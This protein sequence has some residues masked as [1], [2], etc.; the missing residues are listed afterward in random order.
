MGVI[1]IVHPLDDDVRPWLDE[2]G[3]PYPE[4]S[5]PS[6]H[7][8]PAEVRTSMEA[9]DGYTVDVNSSDVGGL[10]QADIYHTED[11][12]SGGWT[13]ANV[14]NYAGDHEPTSLGFEKGWPE[15]IVKILVPITEFTG[16]LILIPD[17]GEAPVVISAE[18]S[19]EEIVNGWEHTNE[20]LA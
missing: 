18:L 6:R 16:P 14:L 9:L 4:L 13:L 10:W 3:V 2:Q 7:P 12:E 15:L 11:P 5:G 17:T 1:Y 19:P 20:T 8:T